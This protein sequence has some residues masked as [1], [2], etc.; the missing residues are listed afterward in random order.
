MY[1]LNTESA[2]LYFSAYKFEVGTFEETINQIMSR[3]ETGQAENLSILPYS[4]NQMPRFKMNIDVNGKSY[5]AVY[6]ICFRQVDK[7]V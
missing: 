2:P 4:I 7:M 3:G 5:F 1:F 6:V